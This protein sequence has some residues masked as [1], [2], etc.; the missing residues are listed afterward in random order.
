MSDKN[1][2]EEQELLTLIAGG[3]EQ[4]FYRLFTSYTPLLRPFAR[5][6]THS[7]TDAEEI[8]QESFIRIWLYRD[9]IMEVEN[10]RSW[11]FTVAAH[12]CMSYMR[13]KITYQQKMGQLEDR[14]ASERENTPLEMVQLSEVIRIIQHTVAKMPPQRK[15]I[16]RL[17]RDESMKPADIARLLSLSVST[18]KNVL[19]RALKE[20]R[21]E[22][23]A[24]GL[25]AGL[26]V[27]YFFNNFFK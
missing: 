19:S 8:L 5:H 11:I 6:I 12:E 9:K 4:A 16:Y 26:L 1:T 23:L 10:L 14:A 7:E 2:Y 17:S 24:A 20:I 18:V 13:R 22:L 21:E 27:Y 25:G 3:D 15:L